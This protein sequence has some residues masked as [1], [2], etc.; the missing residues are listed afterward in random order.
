MHFSWKGWE[1]VLFN[2]RVK[3]MWC[4]IRTTLC[5]G[6]TAG[7]RWLVLFPWIVAYRKHWRHQIFL[8]GS[9]KGPEWPSCSANME[10][11]SYP[12]PPDASGGLT[13]KEAWESLQINAHTQ[14]G[15][16]VVRQIPRRATCWS[17]TEPSARPPSAVQWACDRLSTGTAEDSCPVRRWF[18]PARPHVRP[19]RYRRAADAFRCLGAGRL[20]Q[21]IWWGAL[22]FPQVRGPWACLSEWNGL[23]RLA[24][25]RHRCSGRVLWRKS[26]RSCILWPLPKPRS[27]HPVQ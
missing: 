16:P 26:R 20:S 8:K 6:S 17:K 15:S 24:V 18:A 5:D 9:Q 23:C 11:T 27:P 3:G 7:D 19:G 10:S 12:C 1:N 22:W 4:S 13:H 25:R 14:P 21:S 2:L